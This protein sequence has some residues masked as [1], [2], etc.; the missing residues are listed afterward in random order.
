MVVTIEE[1]SKSDWTKVR[2]ELTTLV[3]EA[4]FGYFAMEIGRGVIFNGAD[5]DPIEMH[6]HAYTN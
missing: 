1:T 6:D 4:G 3:G 5:K 2:D